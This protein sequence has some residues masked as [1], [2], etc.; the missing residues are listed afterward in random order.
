ML[1]AAACALAAI[2]MA[3]ANLPRGW[4]P[5]TLSGKISMVDPGEKLVV[6]QTPDGVSFD[7]VVTGT[8]RIKS[9]DRTVPLNDLQQ[10]VNKTVSV[11]FTPERRGDVARSIEIGG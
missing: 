2:P 7:M 10:D 8:T 5:E 1:A 6:V 9:G 11:R 4:P 3:A